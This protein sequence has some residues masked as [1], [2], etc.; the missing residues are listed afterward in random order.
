[1]RN[2]NQDNLP[3]YRVSFARITGQDRQGRD[4]LARPKEIGAVWPRKNGKQGGILQLDII[5]IELTQRQGVIFL[6]PVDVQD[7]GG[8]Q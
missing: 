6:V 2:R 4:E 8:S 5:P 1:M 7:Q 3:L